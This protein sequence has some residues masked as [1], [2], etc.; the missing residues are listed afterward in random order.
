MK[1]CVIQPRYSFDPCELDACVQGLLDQ[2]DECDESMDLILLP[3]YS[4]ALADVKGEAGFYGAV[5]KYNA[6][7]LEKARATAKRCHS[8]LFVNAGYDS[9]KGV[10]NTTYAIDREGETVGKYF[11]AHPAP[12]EVKRDAEGGHGLD[13]DYSYDYAEPYILEL[14]GIRFAFLTCYDF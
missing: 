6:L 5:E 1:I 14:E 9:G 3:E 8:L 10:R 11:K 2:L 7:L 4:D 12:S 13:V